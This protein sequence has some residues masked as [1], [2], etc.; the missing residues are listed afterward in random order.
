MKSSTVLLVLIF[1]LTSCIAERD[2]II[3]SDYSYHGKFKKYDTFNFLTLN[4]TVN[5]NGLSDSM[6]KHE[7][8][9]R[10][11]A[12]GYEKSDK[13]SF[14]VAYKVYGSDLTFRGY[15]QIDLDSWE[16]NFAEIAE[17]EST[18][19]YLKE[20]KYVDREYRLSEGTLLIDFIDRKTSGLI[21]QGYAS[22]LFSNQSYFSKDI[23]YSVRMILNEYRVLAANYKR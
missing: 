12:Q 21:W 4:D 1:L 23:R 22:G 7:I 9:R 18:L 14:Y 3:E 10:L 5:F 15:D 13:P 20:A 17:N 19:E 16:Q 11:N 8:E 2:L 6:I